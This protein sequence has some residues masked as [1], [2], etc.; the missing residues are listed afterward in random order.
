MA[1]KIGDKFT[2]SNATIR[3]IPAGS[4]LLVAGPGEVV[5]TG[6]GCGPTSTVQPVTKAKSFSEGDQVDH[7]KYGSGIVVRMSSYLT[8]PSGGK[9]DTFVAFDE[10]VVRRVY[11]SDLQ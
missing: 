1:V 3:Q 9:G 11:A 6:L 10:G 4:T 5:V 8:Q 2:T 7:S